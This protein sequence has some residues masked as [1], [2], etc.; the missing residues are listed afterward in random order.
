MDKTELVLRVGVDDIG[1]IL[2]VS[3]DFDGNLKTWAPNKVT[4]KAIN[5]VDSGIGVTEHESTEIMFESFG[6]ESAKEIKKE[7]KTEYFY[8]LYEVNGVFRLADF[9]GSEEKTKSNV[10]NWNEKGMKAVVVTGSQLNQLKSS[11]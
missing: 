2:P 8:I 9:G 1:K 3:D 4:I 6:V 7:V 11:K 10:K 5:D